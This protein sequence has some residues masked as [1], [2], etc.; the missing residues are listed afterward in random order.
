MLYGVWIEKTKHKSEK[1]VSLYLKKTG[2][3]VNKFFNL[4]AQARQFGDWSLV[5][6]VLVIVFF[7]Y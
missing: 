3:F 1:E 4:F 7:K 2:T 6:T 5:S